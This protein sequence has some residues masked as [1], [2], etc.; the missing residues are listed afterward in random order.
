VFSE[1]AEKTF[2]RRLVFSESIEKT[3]CRGVVFSESVEKTFCR[4]HVIRRNH[5]L[6]R[7]RSV[8]D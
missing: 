2:C 1:S 8:E 7:R 4:E 5:V 6:Q 3:F